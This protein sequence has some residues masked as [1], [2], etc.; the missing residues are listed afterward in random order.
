MKTG[1]FVPGRL[2][3]AKSA[4]LVHSARLCSRAVCFLAILLV[5]VAAVRAET[6]DKLKPR[7]Y[8]ND[9]GGVLDVQSQQRL[10]AL[11]KEV[12]D[13]THA[14]IAVVTVRTLEGVPVEDFANKLYVRW[15]IGY[16]GENRG[17][18]VLLSVNDRKYR[19]E[20]G[21]G[22]EPILPDGKVGGFS[23]E[24]VPFLRQ[25]DYGGALLHVTGRIA[26]VIA[27]DRRVALSTIP[28]T[29]PPVAVTRPAPPAAQGP[30]WFYAVF[31]VVF[32]ILKGIFFMLFIYLAYRLIKAV[33][34]GGVAGALAGLSTR[35]YG[36]RSGWSSSSSS[37]S[38]SSGGFGGS[39]SGG[40]GGGSSGGGGASGSW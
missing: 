9:F 10:T 21:Y 28:R 35:S 16:K 22:L 15:G 1:M 20:V 39:S 31:V 32:G 12:D 2:Q 19:V 34:K 3:R 27:Q 38:S 29:A 17:V 18:L 14:Q 23:R 7:G 5:L 30:W 4:D 13:K 6:P 33:A 11:C 26:E 36:T 24:I 8:V 25:G 40:F 37:S